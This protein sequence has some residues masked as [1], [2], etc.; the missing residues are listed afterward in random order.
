MKNACY[1]EAPLGIM[2]IYVTFDEKKS[3]Y[4]ADREI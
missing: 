1:K 2:N 4:G 3:L